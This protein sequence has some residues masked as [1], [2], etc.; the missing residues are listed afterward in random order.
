MPLLFQTNLVE[1]FVKFVLSVS[2]DTELFYVTHKLV[3][4]QC[5]ENHEY[6]FLLVVNTMKG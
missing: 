3:V 5:S 2:L 6:I 1:N 4:V